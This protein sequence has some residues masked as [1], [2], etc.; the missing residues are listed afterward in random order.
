MSSSKA[1][2]E[3]MRESNYARGRAIPLLDVTIGEQLHFTASRYGYRPALIVRHQNVRFTWRELDA[4]VTE[5]AR[6]LAGMGYGKGDRV[7]IW[8]TNCWQW[9]VLQLACARAGIV[10]V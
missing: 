8:S 4:K 7:G 3:T 5:W 9:V 2:T 10:L 1:K 6:G